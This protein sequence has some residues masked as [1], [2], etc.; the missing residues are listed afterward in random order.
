MGNLT[1]Q[2]P[3]MF[4]ILNSL[5]VAL[6]PSFCTILQYCGPKGEP[7]GAERVSKAAAARRTAWR[8][9]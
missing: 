9:C 1:S 4:W 5:K 2:E 3:T 8:G 6:K 7:G